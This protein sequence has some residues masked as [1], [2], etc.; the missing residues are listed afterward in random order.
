M[1]I[2]LFPDRQVQEENDEYPKYCEVSISP[3]KI[4]VLSFK[5]YQTFASAIGQAESKNKTKQKIKQEL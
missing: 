4:D 2:Q 3:Q 1:L 5:D